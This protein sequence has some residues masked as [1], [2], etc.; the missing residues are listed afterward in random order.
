MNQMV[1]TGDA[2]LKRILLHQL[3][4]RRIPNQQVHQPGRT[5]KLPRNHIT[6]QDAH[7]LSQ[8]R[9]SGTQPERS[10]AD[11]GTPARDMQS[12]R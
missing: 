12:F 1:R 11:N 4:G 10:Q 9:F 7:L 8:R 3:P 2:V 6:G 5:L